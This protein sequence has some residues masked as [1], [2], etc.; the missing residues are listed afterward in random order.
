MG[1]ILC[2]GYSQITIVC[3]QFSYLIK[4]ERFFCCL[5]SLMLILPPF[6]LFCRQAWQKLGAMPPEDAMQKYIDIVT[7][8][9]PTWLD[10]SSLVS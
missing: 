6:P 8:L 1:N 7:E 4:K 3:S 9:Y 2:A 10:G 5:F